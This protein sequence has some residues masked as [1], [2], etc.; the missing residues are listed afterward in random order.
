VLLNACTLVTPAD[1]LFFACPYFLLGVVVLLL[2]FLSQVANYCVT[3]L[4]ELNVPLATHE[5]GLG[6]DSQQPPA[7]SGKQYLEL[8]CNGMVSVNG[9]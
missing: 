1:L 5:V 7:S 8:T 6:P 3:K 4:A 9:W 2:L